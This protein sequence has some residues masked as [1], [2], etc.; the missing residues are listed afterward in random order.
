MLLA[1]DTAT[2]YIS[3]ALHNGKQI[4]AESSWYSPNN[5]TLTLA[6]ETEALFVKAGIEVADLTEVAVCTGPGSYTGLRV[7]VSF[8]KAIAS[9][10]QLPLIA[11]SS[12]DILAVAQ[13]TLSRQLIGVIQAGRGR[14][15]WQSFEFT[16]KGQWSPKTEPALSEWS[17]MLAQIEGT[18]MISGEINEDVVDAIK[19]EKA[20]G[21]SIVIAPPA[22][23]LRRAGFLAEEA[24][25][26]V[27]DIEP[28]ARLEKFPSAQVMPVY[29]KTKD[30]ETP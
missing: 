23:G 26:Q 28:E 19:A 2:Q 1:I 25:R 8:A 14:V 5:H 10:R 13:P 29:L 4:L 20:K 15:I 11:L 27:R 24:L 21:K 17:E 16:R 7:G 3:I 9:A 18:T 22:F 30:K 12:L 6:S